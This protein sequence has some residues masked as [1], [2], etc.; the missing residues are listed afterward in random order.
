M[1][2][3]KPL[4]DRLTAGPAALD[5]LEIHGPASELAKSKEQTLALGH[6]HVEFFETEM[7]G[8]HLEAPS[9]PEASASSASPLG[10][11]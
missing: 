5:R 4:M 1:N 7:V 6:G 2:H 11:L 10:E 9:Q 8:K 3:V